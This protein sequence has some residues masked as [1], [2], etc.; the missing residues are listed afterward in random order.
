M[1]SPQ[2]V[3]QPEGGILA[4]ERCIRAHVAA[5]EAAGAELHERETVLSWA[6]DPS[7]GGLRVVTDRDSYTANRLIMTAGSWIGELVE[8]LK[9]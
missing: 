4:S 6:E 8:P 7:T 3:Y 5:A 9:V 1:I 2:A